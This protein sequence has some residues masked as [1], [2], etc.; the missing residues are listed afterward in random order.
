MC[1]IH[2]FH[3]LCGHIY[4]RTLISCPRAVDQATLA[5]RESTPDGDASA[6][7]S[8]PVDSLPSPTPST[9][10]TTSFTSSSST[11]E[12][13]L[14]LL[15]PMFPCDL[16]PQ[17]RHSPSS[18]RLNPCSTA[19]NSPSIVP[20]ACEA[21]AELEALSCSLGGPQ[22][23]RATFGLVEACTEARVK[24][25][26]GSGSRRTL[27][28]PSLAA[29]G[30]A[31]HSYRENEEDISADEEMSPIAT[32]FSRGSRSLYGDSSTTATSEDGVVGGSLRCERRR[33]SSETNDGSNKARI[34]SVRK[35]IVLS[36]GR[37]AE[38]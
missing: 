37:L 38:E 10:T 22:E 13:D 16:I 23:A 3:H 9:Y 17:P 8:S 7:P 19:T 28:R 6:L 18:Q 14:E 24:R 31:S 26:Q 21:C 12:Q 1:N 27:D 33:R 2:T 34:A 32:T 29:T 35:R 15:S 5:A 30:P 36:I 25:S 20:F 4:L 11:N